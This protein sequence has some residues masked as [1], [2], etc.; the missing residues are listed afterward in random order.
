MSKFFLA[1][2]LAGIH[3]AVLAFDHDHAQWTALL[4][5]HVVVSPDGN[6][7]S[8]RYAGMQRDHSQL[9]AYLDALSAVDEA[10]YRS[11]SRERQLAFLINAYNAFT[12]DLVL[13]RY[14]RL[15]SIKEIGGLFRSP[16]KRK[17]FTLL[18][19]PRSLDDVEH[20][21]IRAPGVFDEPR[22]HV[23]V[24]CASI[25]CPML[26]P[27]AFTA[28]GIEAQLE[29]SMRRFLSDRTRN[30]FD[31]DTGQ[32]AVSR[33]FDWYADDFEQGHQGFDSLRS[34][35]ARYA[36]QLATTP[37]SAARIR[38]G[39]YRLGFLDYDWTLN[40]APGDPGLAADQHGTNG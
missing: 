19:E 37:E 36:N 18:G 1:V 24:V 40:D 30:R 31:P 26:P 14:P 12:V 23:A 20:G 8:V 3:T 27:E 34:T 33:I 35:F 25:G 10:A 5:R 4:E 32:L 29:D 13:T 15:E 2:L 38:V 22:I 9:K 16:W 11:W 28:E 21:M 6:A 17:F 39:D 7:S